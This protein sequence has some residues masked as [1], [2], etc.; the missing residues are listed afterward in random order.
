MKNCTNCVAKTKSQISFA[1]TAQLICAF[2]FAL[3]KI[4]YSHNV[5]LMLWVQRCCR[6]FEVV[7]CIDC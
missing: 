2:V 1:V 4:R 6:L 7:N 5:A 3:A